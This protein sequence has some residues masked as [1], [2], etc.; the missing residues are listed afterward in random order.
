MLGIAPDRHSRCRPRSANADAPPRRKSASGGSTK[1]K[2]K[3]GKKGRKQKKPQVHHGKPWKFPKADAPIEPP[4]VAPPAIPYSPPKRP[5]DDVLQRTVA[6]RSVPGE[7]H[8]PELEG[9]G[10]MVF[11]TDE[12]GHDS[13]GDDEKIPV[14]SNLPLRFI[15]VREKGK[16][17]IYASTAEDDTCTS[18]FDGTTSP[19]DWD[20]GEK[21]KAVQ[22]IL[23]AVDKA[24][25]ERAE[26]LQKYG[27][28]VD[29]P[30]VKKQTAAE[31]WYTQLR[32]DDDRLFEC[33]EQISDQYYAFA[34][35]HRLLG[36][37]VLNYRMK[38]ELHFSERQVGILFLVLVCRAPTFD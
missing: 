37:A 36:R 3:N 13:F 22:E 15:F 16:L 38:N 24:D 32:G 9:D 35:V 28:R 27:C 5:S 10:L 11:V 21:S 19:I 1:K 8:L 29:V 6:L 34:I 20:K 25:N 18:N 7:E 31:L 17:V 2:A 23:D 12:K 4:A 33:Y 26:L 30:R 14:L